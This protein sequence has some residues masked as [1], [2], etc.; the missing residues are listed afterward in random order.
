MSRRDDC[1]Q[2]VNVALIVSRS[3]RDMYNLNEFL[4]ASKL[5]KEASNFSS[6]RPQSQL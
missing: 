4:T 6:C 3:L 1:L 2:L 5:V